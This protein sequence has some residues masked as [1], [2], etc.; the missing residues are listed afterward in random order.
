MAGQMLAAG[1][2]F[3]ALTV[4]R[5]FAS[6]LIPGDILV[7]NL[8]TSNVQEYEPD[9]TLVHTFKGTGTL[10]EGASLTP[11]GELVTT[12]RSP[13][14]GG[15]DVF[16]SA[17]TQILTFTTP[18]IA[19]NQADVSVFPDG[20]FAVNNQNPAGYAL[21]EY[22]STGTFIRAITLPDTGYPAGTYVAPNGTLWVVETAGPIMNMEENGTLLTTIDPDFSGGVSLVVN[23]SD[24]SIYLSDYINDLVHHFSSTGSVLGQF[25]TSISGPEGIGIASDGTLYID[26]D[27]DLVDHYSDSGTLL[28]A[29]TL[30]NPGTPLYLSVIPLPEPTFLALGTITSLGLLARPRIKRAQR[31]SP[32][33]L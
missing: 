31:Q 10:F 15:V 7:N 13:S 3:C 22:S 30:S 6:N 23:P 18:Q 29:I 19:S 28:G 20:V 26:G 11:T 1:L 14:P 33:A 25:S 12:Y 27:S 17:G 16:N 24:N 2:L 5:S 32:S 9:G 21:D 4:T 8:S